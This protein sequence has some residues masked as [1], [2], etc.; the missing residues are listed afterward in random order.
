MG[1]R[2]EGRQKRRRER[3]HRPYATTADRGIKVRGYQ[4]E[5]A[6]MAGVIIAYVLSSHEG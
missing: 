6:E 1:W 4:V 2:T 3:K 5:E